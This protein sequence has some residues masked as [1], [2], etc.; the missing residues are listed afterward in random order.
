MRETAVI[1]AN[2][3]FRTSFAK[4][5][6]GLVRGPSRYRIL[7]V[8]DHSCPGEDAGELLD[9]VSCG[10]P[11]FESV[12]AVIE[13]IVPRPDF[14]IVGIATSGGVLPPELRADLVDAA[15]AGLSLVSGLHEL[16]SDDPAL[17]SLTGDH[18]ARIIDIRRPRPT[19][20]L[21]FWTGEGL[22]LE[23]P[24]IAVLGTDCAIG[25][26]TTCSLLLGACRERGLDAGMV[27]TGQTGWMQGHGH[28]FILD[29]TPNDFVCGELEGA[30]LECQ[31]DSEPDVI[32]LEGQSSLRNPSGP[33]GSEFILAGGAKGVI[34][35][36]AP[37]RPFFDE[38]EELSCRIP[39]IEEEIDL[40]RLLGA[41]VLALTLNEEGMSPREAEAARSRLAE[42]L[43]I[44]VVL[45]LR[46]DLGGLVEIVRVWIG[47]GGLS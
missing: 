2:G 35:Q 39:S 41:E 5:A 6:H 34:L 21:R 16:L 29:A 42:D 46:D 18:G 12:G 32:M 23:T 43:G 15:R 40:I 7:G 27:Y 11:V 37:A 36:H 22:S 17:V 20:E 26:R 33:C 4:T 30:I 45:P 24:R 38:L 47:G 9:G 19:S 14:C 25:K 8:I 31:R 44:P 10:I 13:A 3:L 1:L 28:G